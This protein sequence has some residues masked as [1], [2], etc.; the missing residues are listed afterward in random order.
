MSKSLCKSSSVAE[1]KLFH[2]CDVLSSTCDYWF[3]NICFCISFVSLVRKVWYCFFHSFGS[4]LIVFSIWDQVLNL[5]LVVRFSKKQWV[6]VRL[7]PPQKCS[8]FTGED[9]LNWCV[10]VK[11]TAN[12]VLPGKWLPPYVPFFWK[13]V[14]VTLTKCTFDLSFV[15]YFDCRLNLYF[16][17]CGSFKCFKFLFMLLLIFGLNTTEYVW[18]RLWTSHEQNSRHRAI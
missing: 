15:Y 9:Y 2:S 4:L 11:P 5:C 12:Q 10:G 8:V 7:F 18:L 3:I 16:V 14:I 17:I 13:I 1:F 6:V